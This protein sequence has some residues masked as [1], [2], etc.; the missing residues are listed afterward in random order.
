MPTLSRMFRLFFKIGLFTLGGG[1]AIL[2]VM[3]DEIVKKHQWMGEE[4]FRQYIAVVQGTPGSLA[5][6]CSAMVGFRLAGLK[7]AMFS[8]LGS[9]LPSFLVITLLA[10]FFLDFSSL[11][12]VQ[13][14]FSGIRPAVV[15]MIGYFALKL[16]RRTR[17]NLQRGGLFLV[18]VLLFLLAGINPVLLI[19]GAALMGFLTGKGG[20]RHDSVDHL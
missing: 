8:A 14:F 13:R 1:Y 4:E 3:E 20:K 15:A 7:G 17:W 9:V 5:V 11:P 10:I 19:L 12:L 2:P 6:N 18:S 16:I